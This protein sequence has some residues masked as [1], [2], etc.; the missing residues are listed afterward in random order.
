[1]VLLGA[2][3]DMSVLCSHC[4]RRLDNLEDNQNMVVTLPLDI[5]TVQL[6]G[7]GEHQMSYQPL[8]P[9][10]PN[11]DS[12]TTISQLQSIARCDMRVFELV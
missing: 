7:S 11:I 12:V 1:M 9:A 5:V 6:Q 4:A 10:K 3:V 2:G 8:K